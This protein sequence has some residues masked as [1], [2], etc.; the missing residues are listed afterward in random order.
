VGN[1]DVGHDSESY[2]SLAAA[3]ISPRRSS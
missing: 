2:L 3:T 1:H